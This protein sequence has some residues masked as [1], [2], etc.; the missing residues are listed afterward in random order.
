MYSYE[1]DAVTG[2]YLLNSTP[3]S[4]SKEPRPVYYQEMDLLGFDKYWDYEKDDTYPYMW[5]EA[6]K[7]WY[8]GHL[9]A[10]LKGGTLYQAPDL[11]PDEEALKEIR[12]FFPVDIAEMVARNE[13]ILGSLV[14]DTIKNAY[15]TYIELDCYKESRQEK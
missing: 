13:G 3:L 9:V 14:A 10:Q 15:N 2:G 7:Y 11:I 6:N 4:F 1:W 12:R 5:A 8:R